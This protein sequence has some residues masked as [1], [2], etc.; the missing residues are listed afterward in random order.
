MMTELVDELFRGTAQYHTKFAKICAPLQNYFGINAVAYVSMNNRGELI[1][2]HT[3]VPWMERCMEKH[4]YK[5]DPGMVSPKNIAS[6]FTIDSTYK[7]S[8]YTDIMMQDCFNTF[9]LCYECTYV[10]KN[11]NSYQLFSF[12]APKTN[13][14][15]ISRVISEFQTLKKFIRYIQ[16][17][18]YNRNKDITHFK[19]N[20]AK[21]K[22]PEFY[23]QQGI[24]S[25]NKKENARK[26]NIL[27]DIGMIHY[28]L[29]EISLSD[30]EKQCLRLY[31][32]RNTIKQV[33]R[34]M[35]ISDKTSNKHL[36]SITNK[37]NC[38]TRIELV[39]QAEILESLGVL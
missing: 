21:T 30:Q 34:F 20:F 5:C 14:N 6:G 31:S 10:E 9:D 29:T 35:N 4:Y 16:S 2:L 39:R 25:I 37:F 32:E 15:F 3:H 26:I 23:N 12:N 36:T 19:F 7:Q 11:K 38:S 27:K 8:E 17:E 33:A 22:G 18:L 13:A 24:I 28:N 1:N